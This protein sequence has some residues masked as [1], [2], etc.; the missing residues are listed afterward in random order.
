MNIEANA[1]EKTKKA[2]K[3]LIFK[4]LK[5]FLPFILIIVGIFFAICTLIDAIFIQE[6][7]APDSSMPEAQLEIKNLCIEKAEYLNTCHNYIGTEKTEYL[8]DIDSREID[9]QVEWSHL[10]AIM[11][12]HNMTD[13]TK[14]NNTLLEKVSKHF[15]STFTYEKTTV[16]VETSM[17]D[18]NGK[19]TT[20]S[21][22]ETAYILIESD[23]IIRTL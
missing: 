19:T 7:Q 5:P 12:F 22:E 3:K 14:I 8:L 2:L 18:K 11:A 13:N 4:V 20:T 6:V 1:K 16:K 23:S 10:Y 17:T 21:S 15:E 9:K